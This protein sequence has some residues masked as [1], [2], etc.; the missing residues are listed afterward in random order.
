[1]ITGTV[2]ASLEP[3]IRVE[4]FADSINLKVIPDRK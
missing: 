2:N 4:E 3:I 1:M